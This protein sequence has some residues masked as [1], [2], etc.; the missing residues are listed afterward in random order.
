ME[1]IK[2][3]W[4][5]VMVAWFIVNFELLQNLAGN[6]AEKSTFVKLFIEPLISCYKCT[7]FWIVTFGL[8]LNITLWDQLI[9]GLSV[10][11]LVKTIVNFY[12][13]YARRKN[14]N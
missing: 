9:I 10:S 7:T 11:F 2:Q 13:I 5:L 4:G 6:L 3:I 14:R 1:E 12:D 8:F